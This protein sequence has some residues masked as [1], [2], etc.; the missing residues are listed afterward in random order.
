MSTTDRIVF[1]FIYFFKCNRDHTFCAVYNY[2]AVEELA[3]SDE[4]YE[5]KIIIIVTCLCLFNQN[6]RYKIVKLIVRWLELGNLK[7]KMKFL[8]EISW[9]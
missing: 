1:F 7:K 8:Y 3:S 5:T 9:R 2:V 4:L 6:C